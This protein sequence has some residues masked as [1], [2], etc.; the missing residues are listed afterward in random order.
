MTKLA[1]VR[2]RGQVR[3]VWDIKDTLNNLGLYRPN[4][5][6]IVE[7]TPVFLGMIKKVDRHI[8]WGEASEETLNLLEKKR[9][10]TKNKKGE[11]VYKKFLR[12]N[13]PRKGYGRKGIKK[14]F[15]EK[16][17]LGYRGDK[18]NELIKRML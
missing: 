5:C 16:G 13:P 12:L 8:T 17:A 3:M 14:S 10:K 1:L 18:I 4:Y 11:V 6:V 2:V 7:K 9:E 15:Q